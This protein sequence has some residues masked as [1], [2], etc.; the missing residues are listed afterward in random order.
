MAD[1]GKRI[2]DIS[3]LLGVFEAQEGEVQHIIGKTGQ[4]KTYEATRRALRYLYSGYTVY[5]TWRLNLP[6]YYDERSHF[7]PLLRNFILGKKEFYRFDLKNNWRHIDL[8]EG[9]FVNPE[10]KIIDVKKLSEFVAKITDAIV[11]LDEG[12]DVFDSHT[13][14]TAAARQTITRTRHMHKTL[15]VISQRAQ[16]VDVTARANVTFFYKCVKKWGWPKA[17]FQVYITDEIDENTSYPIWVRHNSQGMETWKAPVWRSGW[18]RQ[19]IYD[20]YD[21]WYLRQNMIKSQDI[22]FEA[23]SLSFPQRLAALFGYLAP[24]K[25]RAT[26]EVSDY[27]PGGTKLEQQEAGIHGTELN[28]KQNESNDTEKQLSRPQERA[29]IFQNEIKKLPLSH[30]LNLKAK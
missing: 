30:V 22:S 9:E 4:G 2:V 21:S 19:Y 12:Q 16:A 24:K 26:I 6:D 11:M 28:D 3:P 25:R 13:K 20:S 23:Y 18:A 14:G 15:I 10:T 8:L 27:E 29:A 7:W 1:I 17:F 5:T